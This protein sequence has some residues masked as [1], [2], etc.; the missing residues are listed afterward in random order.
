MPKKLSPQDLTGPALEL[1][2]ARFRALGE[3]NRLRLIIALESGGKNVGDLVAATGLSQPNVSR[4][5]QTL[6]EAGLLAR[7]KEGLMVIYSIADPTVF[8]LCEQVCGGV[9]KR[10]QHQAKAFAPAS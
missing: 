9:Q 4:H 1:I 3:P 8:D 6:I 5:L 2:A 10:L 7:R